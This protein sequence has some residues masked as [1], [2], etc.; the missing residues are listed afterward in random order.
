MP[1]SSQIISECS[2]WALGKNTITCYSRITKDIMPWSVTT[3]PMELPTVVLSTLAEGHL[4]GVMYIDM[5]SYLL[6]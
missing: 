5:S 2:N 3:P 4:D 6:W 1:C